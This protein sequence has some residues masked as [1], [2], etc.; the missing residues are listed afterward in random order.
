M[1]DLLRV[2]IGYDPRQAL[3]YNTLQFSIVRRAKKPVSITPL[4]IE[5]LPISRVGLTPF[6][7][8]RF[9]VP[10]L[11]DYKG[12]ALFMDAD[13]LVLDDISKLFELADD[14]Y[15]VMVSKNKKRF[16]WASMM[17]FNC[18]K[19]KSLTPDYVG[20]ADGLHTISWANEEEVG[21]LPRDW[22]HL[23]GYDSLNP[24]PKNVHFTQ[25]MPCYQE[26]R[27]SE[28]AEKWNEEFRKL[29]FISPWVELMGKSVHAVSVNGRLM[30]RFLI[31]EKKRCP[32]QGHEQAVQSI[33]QE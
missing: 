10:W 8:T 12:W 2:F 5:Q 6:T 13:M 7:F 24:A 17:L 19:C 25:G 9:L 11:C 22:N 3:S 29:Q 16:E 21:D 32:A 33:L 28:H 26:T 4:V 18:K 27:T 23:V 31:N 20:E 14:K 15:S 30:P 1:P